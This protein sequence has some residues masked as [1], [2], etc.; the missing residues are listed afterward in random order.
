V[1]WALRRLLRLR[2]RQRGESAPEVRNGHG[3]DEVGGE[4]G[5]VGAF[6]IV[7]HTVA[8]QGDPAQSVGRAK[9]LHELEAGAV[10][11]AQIRNDQVKRV[12]RSCGQ[13]LGDARDGDDVMSV[14]MQ[15]LKERL[16]GGGVI[17]DYEQAQRM[18]VFM[19]WR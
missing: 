15:Q 11:Q 4:T 8:A 13:R 9:F 14:A 3:L 10:G 18:Q 6:Q 12:R 2:C 5:G 1:L 17:F 16:Q 7:A 19:R